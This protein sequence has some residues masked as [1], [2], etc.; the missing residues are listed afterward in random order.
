MSDTDRNIN[1]QVKQL[2]EKIEEGVRAFRSSEEFKNY[3]NV[4]AALPQYSFRNCCLI[5]QQCMERGIEPQIVQSYTAWSRMGRQ[6][7]EG[8][9]G[10]KILAPCTYKTQVEREVVDAD[11]NTKTEKVEIS[12]ASYKV[13]TTFELSQTTG[14]EI[15]SLNI[16]LLDG[17]VDDY[18]LLK[19]AI[20]Q[21]SPVP[22]LFEKIDGS[23]NGYYSITDKRIVIDEELPDRHKIHTLLHEIAHATL[24]L[25]GTDKYKK[26]NTKEIEAE[27][28]SF[29][30]MNR[31]LGT[32]ITSED[33]G[34]Y[35]FGYCASWSTDDNMKELKDS[36]KVIQK[37]SCELIKNIEDNVM[38]MRLRNVDE[39]AYESEDSFFFIQKLDSGYNC[40]LYN[41]NTYTEI[42]GGFICDPTLRIDKASEVGCRLVGRSLY[43]MKPIS[44]EDY[45]NKMKYPTIKIIP[46]NDNSQRIAIHC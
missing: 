38:N 34:Q 25:N 11:G 40:T 5:Y 16:K 32:Q 20:I 43:M 42:D 26:R 6:V 13:V 21:S 31:L 10:I 12:H 3:L 45:K 37:T 15:P 14:K 17:I 44:I 1:N 27:S 19:E 23:A 28:I 39:L 36:L 33:I 18:E 9:H 7:K 29:V 8:E 24:E 4:M 22:I 30:V 2:T 46:E 35:S 41:K